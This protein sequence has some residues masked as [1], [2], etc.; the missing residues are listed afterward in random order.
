MDR[1]TPKNNF[2]RDIVAADVEAGTYDGRVVTRF[3][4]EPNGYPHIGHAQSICLN[5]GLAEQFGGATNL[6][7]DDTNPEAESQEFADALLDAVRWL[8][9]EPAEVRYASDYFEQFY[10]WAQ[11]LVRKGLAYVDSQSDEEIRQTR[12][13]V[14]EAGTPSPYRDRSV[15]E[16]L[17]LLEEMKRGEHPDG[18]HVLRA[19]VDPGP[20]DDWPVMGHPNMKL[21]DPLMYRIRR[22]AHHYRRGDEWAIYPLYD[23]A[24]G[25]GDA[26]EGITHSICTLEFDVNRPLYDWYL[27]AIGVEE[28]RNHQHE[29]AR[30][31]L[32][33]TV[34]SKRKLRQ[35]VEG[36][37]VS[38]WDDPRMPTIAGLRRRGV[39]PEALRRFFADLG[40]TKV[41]GSV[42]IQQLEYALRDDLNHVA[43]RV[44]AVTD[45]VKLTIE[46]VDGTT[47]VDA[48]Y[49][50]HDVT[51]PASAPESRTLP[52]SA[53]VWI[54]R[55]DFS[56]DPP[57][58]WKRLAPGV[59]VRL[60]HGPVVECLGAE[61]DE[62]GEIT[63]IHARLT[64]DAKPTGVIH[65]VDA[66]QGLPAS[67]RMYDRLFSVPDPAG[68]DDFLST[69]NP[70]SLVEKTGYVEPSVADDPPDTR[71][72][73]ER[74]GYF[75]RDPEDSLPGAL[76]FNR[77]VALRDS[78]AKKEEPAAPASAP[79][80]KEPAAPAGPR[81]PASAL[82]D[83]E[84]ETYSALVVRGVG[85]EEAAVLAADP[86]LRSLFESVLT[87]S[88]KPREAGA[89]VV[90]DLRRALGDRDLSDSKA[91]A[92]QLAAVLGLV[93]DGTL[94]RNA[95]GE[96][97]AALVEEGGTAEAAVERRGLA[98]VRSADALTPAVDAALADNPDE[99]ARYRAGEERLFGFFV[100]QVMRRAGKG[101]DPRAVQELLRQR[102]AG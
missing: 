25:Q 62:A 47:E 13:T 78:W 59:A 90:H 2:L 67:F 96:A 43:R 98:A 20:G 15:E 100:G 10:A 34:M 42:E 29:F 26:I 102:L 91:E 19:K 38:G 61:R 99:V 101:A 79:E 22:D 45:P 32:D 52:L 57:K 31:N 81:D 49:W 7:Y 72:Q 51:P 50:P 41:N 33:Y 37:H 89:L 93:D 6:R 84:R 71:Y 76:V 69:L 30:F 44:M 92:D 83:K 55:D 24:H 85:E 40:V 16:N 63:H 56:D 8:G 27:D 14:T 3:P 58:G 21:R 82:S 54:E 48:P 65:W 60:R 11:G 94:T 1:E 35:L 66:E 4:P 17:R 18:A 97:V 75:W 80:P 46:G 36:G 53:A 39:R 70:D 23:W 68:A 74:I 12:G 88:G 77:I 86:T 9:F 73:F 64:E 87:A 5:F 28:P 95:A